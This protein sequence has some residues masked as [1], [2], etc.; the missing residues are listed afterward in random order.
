MSTSTACCQRTPI[1][2]SEPVPVHKIAGLDTYVAGNISSKN[3]VI[4]VY[5]IFG[6]YPQTLK[7]ADRLAEQ[8][9]AVAL[10]PDYLEGVYADHSWTPPDRAAFFVNNAA[11]PKVIPK[12]QAT[13]AEAKTKFPSVE[14]WAILGL[15][16]GGKLAALVSTEGTD[17][18]ASG[19][20]HPGLLDPNDA[21]SITIPHI[22]L[23]S[24][25]EDAAV[26]AE[27]KTA[28]EGRAGL[29]SYVDTYSNMHHGWMGARAN[30]EDAENKKEFERG[31]KEIGDF[32]AKYLYNQRAQLISSITSHADSTTGGTGNTANKGGNIA[33]DIIANLGA[34]KGG[35]HTDGNT[36]AKS[37]GAADS[38]VADAPY[39]CHDD[40][41]IV[42]NYNLKFGAKYTRR[43]IQVR[44]IH[45]ASMPASNP[46]DGNLFE[47]TTT[48]ASGSNC[49]PPIT[50]QVPASLP[51]VDA[52]HIDFAIS[53]TMERLLDSMD[54]FSVWA[55][56]TNARFLVY[57]EP[58]A[59]KRQAQRKAQYLG[60]NV[61][62]F[63]SDVDYEN[64]YSLLVKLL[65]ENARSQTTW[66]CIMDD[67]TFYL[68]MPRLVNMLSKY[69]EKMPHYIGS[70]TESDA[71][72]SMFGI[73]AYGGAGMFFSRPLLDE[74]GKV[75]DECDA[76]TDH[77]DGKIAHCVY[78][79]TR[80]KLE[81]AEELH[82]LDLM[83]DASGW[84]EAARVI[85]VS[86]HH[87]KSW[88][89]ADMV[90]ISA[91]GE[92][93]GAECVLRQWKFADGW[94][95]TNG[96]SVIHHGASVSDEEGAF[97]MERTWDDLNG[98]T[99]ESYIRVLGPLRPKETDKVSFRMEDVIVEG[100]SVRQIYIRRDEKDGDHLLELVWH[101][102]S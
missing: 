55:G 32:F 78:Q 69:D 50:V 42:R 85:P 56:N 80:T 95:L 31:Y 2:A 46:V 26:M 90:K 15:C 35:G 1:G 96:Y 41:G 36:G 6:F 87:W 5:D 76:G 61:M 39:S 14:K 67:D 8:L 79:F 22:V 4:V 29:D 19:Q 20:V 92:V 45:G 89:Q 27:Y 3:G 28:L 47:S 59:N 75:W 83:G 13:I 30:L 100:G 64:R 38:S 34:N 77:G 98:S 62:L 65:A 71:Q 53:T 33:A 16:W 97:A 7:G 48:G 51:S 52:S 88:F 91:V 58:G 84:F 37:G 101:L 60:L 17:F 81:I 72:L 21:K 43:S 68:S 44:P 57:I 9:N 25:D 11:P 10:V 99:D 23:A 63:E 12:V 70:V 86:L 82:Q 102:A 94:I 93:C 73:F 40:P 54:A 24:K 74:L 18:V 66:A 49:P